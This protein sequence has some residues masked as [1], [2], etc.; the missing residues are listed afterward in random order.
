MPSAR[1]T[2]KAGHTHDRRHRAGI[3]VRQALLLLAGALALE[4]LVAQGSLRFYWTPLILGLAY[5]AAAAAGGRGGSY[6]AT[7]CVLVG[8]GLAVV[9]LGA[10]RPADVDPAGADLVGAGLGA[11]VGTLLARQ[12]FDVS[13]LGL[14]ATAAAAGF[15]LAISPRAPDLLYD[16]RTFAVAVA[17]VGLINLAL[18]VKPGRRVP[19]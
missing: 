17:I 13:P 11:V 2:T 9:Y 6:W 8:W 16:A 5:L 12:R 3:R 19:A 1:L 7:A 14:G 10:V 15:V 18:A 4:L